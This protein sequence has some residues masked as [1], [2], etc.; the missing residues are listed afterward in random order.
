MGAFSHYRMRK[1]R[2]ELIGLEQAVKWMLH[3]Q[4]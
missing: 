3:K 4:L 1:N 2:Q